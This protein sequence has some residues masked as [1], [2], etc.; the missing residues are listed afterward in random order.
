MK[1]NLQV[2]YAFFSGI[3]LAL[4][5]QN[6]LLPF[7]NPFL[8]L[9]ALV[10]LYIALSSAKTARFAGLLFAIQI[11][12]THL[13]SS[14]WLGFFKDFAIFTLGGT[15]AWYFVS[16][17]FIGQ[18][19]YGI[20]YVPKHKILYSASGKDSWFIPRR[21]LLFTSLMIMYE[22]NKS[23]GFLAYPWGTVYMSAYSWK[24]ICQIASITGTAGISALF[25]LFSSVI[26]E[27]YILLDSARSRSS[28]NTNRSYAMTAVFCISLFA[29]SAVYGVYEY[30]KVREPVKIMDTVLVQQNTDD[31]IDNGSDENGILISQELTTKAISDKE[32]KPDIV[33]WSELV[34][35][36]VYFPHFYSEF[37]EYPEES[38]LLPFIQKTAAPFIIGGYVRFPGENR[39]YANSAVYLDKNAEYLGF[40]AKTRLVPFAELIPYADKAWMRKFMQKLV[41]FSSSWTPGKELRLFSVPLKSGEDAK[42]ANL[43]CF[44]DAFS[45][46]CRSYFALGSE[47][48]L[49]ITNDSWSKTKSAELQHFAVA[50][51]RAIE[52]RTTLVRS[53]NS[54]YSTVVNPA[55]KVL[56]DMPLFTADS[57]YAEVPIYERQVTTY[58]VFGNWLPFLC[59]LFLALS[60]I[61]LVIVQFRGKHE[62]QYNQ[63]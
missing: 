10:P 43:V 46:L 20:F 24:T 41:G 23:T 4:A 54:G 44:E 12:V 11:T 55:G 3:I 58:A 22:W 62:K 59:A 32:K 16:G 5:I 47:V 37:F 18:L 14:F 27:G 60:F 45:D 39:E 7:G 25:I 42:I 6:E 15:V 49:N 48:F 34:L 53:T 38:P 9:I 50:S 28:N 30:S 26:A 33:L 13:L 61:I 29:L 63:G 40:S 2:F 56:Y 8:G 31:W 17:Y 1:R 35:T 36:Y 52:M 21:I 51:F 19:F 57:I